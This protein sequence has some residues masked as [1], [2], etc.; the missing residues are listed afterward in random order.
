MDKRIGFIGLGK[1]GLNMVNRIVKGGI[2]VV[3]HNRSHEPIKEAEQLGA[4]GTYTIEEF[5]QKLPKQRIIWLMVTAGPVVDEWI[6][7]ILP[8]LKQGDIVVDGGNSNYKDS[9]R[10]CEELKNKGITYMDCGTS[11]GIGGA[12]DGYS[13]MA[14]GTKDGF[15]QIEPVLKTLA[16]NQPHGYLHVGPSG[17]GHYVKT[18]HNGI[19]YALCQAY[20]EGLELI[21]K[22]PYNV[23][24]AKLAH[25]WNN[26]SVIRGWLLEL[27]E[28][29][30]KENPTLEGIKGII[31]GGETGTWTVEEA[32]LR[33]VKIPTIELALKIRKDTNKKE[34][35]FSAKVVAVLRNKFGGH[36]VVK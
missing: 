2:E 31:G 5:F 22:G 28:E 26:G 19:E 13:L 4:I 27:A 24:L 7:K 29:A 33:N 30:F 17:A 23:E 9:V 36:E 34:G 32:K 12:K 8:H 25:V 21:T 18:I 16:R 1:M 15:T 35:S 20:G 3:A 11:G 14:G 10:R 6:Q